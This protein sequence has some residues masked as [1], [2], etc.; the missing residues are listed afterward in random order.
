MLGMKGNQ[1]PL[2]RL[3]L[4]LFLLLPPLIPA[5][6]LIRTVK[7]QLILPS[8]ERMLPITNTN[9]IMAAIVVKQRLP[10]ILL[11]PI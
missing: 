5:R 1:R 10:F 9:W 2:G 4:I 11:Y 3:T 8:P 6:L 7:T